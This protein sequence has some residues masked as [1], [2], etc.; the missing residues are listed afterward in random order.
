[1]KESKEISQKDRGIKEIVANINEIRKKLS[2]TTA[3]VLQ[4]TS[5]L[6]YVYDALDSVELTVKEPEDVV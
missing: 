5:A 2:E 1:M 3:S 6:E 4:L